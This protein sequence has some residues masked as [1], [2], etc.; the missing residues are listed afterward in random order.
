M[1]VVVA[2]LKKENEELKAKLEALT[3]SAAVMRGVA[4]MP[5]MSPSGM[6]AA[7]AAAAGSNSNAGSSTESKSP[8]SSGA[9]L[10]PFRE[11][12]QPEIV[13]CE[14]KVV[15]YLHFNPGA[16][17]LC[18]ELA[19]VCFR[20][21]FRCNARCDC[22]LRLVDVARACATA[23]HHRARRRAFVQ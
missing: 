15:Q 14:E 9:P 5:P 12:T 20:V 6:A 13:R 21:F 8:G 2:R 23:C 10:L 22:A 18:D 17:R 16:L 1:T 7:A 3:G 11:L 4:A 19:H